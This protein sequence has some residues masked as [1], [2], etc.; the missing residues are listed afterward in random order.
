MLQKEYPVFMRYVLVWGN[1][2]KPYFTKVLDE[3][4]HH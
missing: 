1:I 4:P 2:L 3:Q